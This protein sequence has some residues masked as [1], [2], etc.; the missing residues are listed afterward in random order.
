M[1]KALARK[2]TSTS[3][4]FIRTSTAQA[5]LSILDF[6]TVM[7]KLILK[8]LTLSLPHCC[9]TFFPRPAFHN[10]GS[11]AAVSTVHGWCRTALL[12]F[13]PFTQTWKEALLIF[14]NN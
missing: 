9:V 14:M 3:S 2:N 11:S 7:F 1:G 10:D 12:Q 8:A 6:K 13:F 4:G 5:Q